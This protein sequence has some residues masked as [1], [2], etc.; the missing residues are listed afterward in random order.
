MIWPVNAITETIE[1][2]KLCSRTQADRARCPGKNAP[3]KSLGFSPHFRTGHSLPQGNESRVRGVRGG[4]LEC[5]PP[6][7]QPEQ[8]TKISVFIAATSDRCRR[9]QR[10]PAPT[11]AC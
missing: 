4:S 5:S 6:A 2:I 9:H 10:P 1:I 11:P 3:L 7:D 8:G